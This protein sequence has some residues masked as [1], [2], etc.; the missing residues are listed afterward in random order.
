[1]LTTP[2]IAQTEMLNEADVINRE[3]F[4]ADLAFERI[5]DGLHNE[6]LLEALMEANE[7]DTKLE[8]MN[9]LAKKLAKELDSEDF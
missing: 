7:S 4:L 1:M 9:R 5:E 8:I 2:D 3:E 6:E